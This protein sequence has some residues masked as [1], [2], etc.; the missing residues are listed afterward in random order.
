[1]ND[2]GFLFAMAKNH[3][4]TGHL[5]QAEDIYRQ[6][7]AL[8]PKHAGSLH[9]LGLIKHQRG[10]PNEAYTLIARS[11]AE[12]SKDAESHNNMGNV[13]RRLGR[14][15]EAIEH[16]SRAVKIAPGFAGAYSNLG[17]TYRQLGKFSEAAEQFRHAIKHDPYLAEAWGGLARTGRL[18]L[19]QEEVSAAEK[20]LQHN[21]LSDSDRRHICFALGKHFDAIEQWD[22]AFQYYDRANQLGG[23]VSESGESRRFLTSILEQ[24]VP[25]LNPHRDGAKTGNSCVTPI[26][27]FGM[28]RSGSTL[29]EQILA[30]HPDVSSGGELNLIETE[31]RHMF[32]KMA[33]GDARF[34]EEMTSDHF[35]H[36][37]Q[38][39]LKHTGLEFEEMP[40]QSL[41]FTDKSLLNF[42]FL[43]VILNVFP[44]ARLVHCRRNPLDTCLSIFFT[45]FKATYDYTNNLDDIGQYFCLY[46]QVMDKWN[47]LMP[48]SMFDARY[49]DFLDDQEETTRRLLEHC[50]LSW[51]SACMNF[52]ETDRQVSTPSDWQ[53]RLPIFSTSKDRWEHY[54]KHL[55]ELIRTLRSCI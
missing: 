27:I 35:E 12:D 3:H 22:K 53:V 51:N 5:D 55:T 43:P 26:F 41:F 33:S 48:D 15:S 45:D 19:K 7:L 13:L 36:L 25:G 6:I 24:P 50:G 31:I 38:A 44:E 14:T 32:P 40:S 49:E 18:S 1:M 9:L 21:K 8:D 54:E 28:P 2:P 30:S 10:R 29:V 4:Q 16:F 34:L 42:A 17:L 23:P 47:A 39:F 37:K 11:L 20:V 52:Y 46:D